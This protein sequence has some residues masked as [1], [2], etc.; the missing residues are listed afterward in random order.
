MPICVVVADALQKNFNVFSVFA[1]WMGRK[2]WVSNKKKY[3]SNSTNHESCLKTE[4]ILP[5]QIPKKSKKTR[6]KVFF[7]D[8]Y[9]FTA[10]PAIHILPPFLGKATKRAGSGNVSGTLVLVENMEKSCLADGSKGLI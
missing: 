4:K 2:F 5:C 10:K 7:L 1:A 3:S 6:E 8:S 9:F